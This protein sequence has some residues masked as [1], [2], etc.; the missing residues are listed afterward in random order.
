MSELVGLFLNAG[1][2]DSLP[3]MFHRDFSTADTF[4]FL[5]VVCFSGESQLDLQGVNETVIPSRFDC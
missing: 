5:S 3:F 1:M 4:I 2:T